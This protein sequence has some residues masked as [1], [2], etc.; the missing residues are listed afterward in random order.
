MNS[1]DFFPTDNKV[2]GY[3]VGAFALLIIDAII[4]KMCYSSCSFLDV[5]KINWIQYAVMF[6]LMPYI[7]VLSANFVYSELEKIK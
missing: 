4:I 3:L 7:L 6:L 1:M 2:Y 5:L